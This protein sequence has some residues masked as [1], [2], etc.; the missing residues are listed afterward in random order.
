MNKK[1][2]G[3]VFWGVV[4]FLVV[5]I[6]G[7]IF[8]VKR[9]VSSDFSDQLI[10]KHNFFDGKHELLSLNSSISM[11]EKSNLTSDG[12]FIAIIGGFKKTSET[13]KMEERIVRF[14]WK[15]NINQFVFSEFSINNVRVIIK[16]NVIPYC[17]FQYDENFEFE[18][19][20]WH[21]SVKWVVLVLN[22]NNIMD[23]SINIDLGK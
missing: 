20:Q 17:T 7:L 21:K 16:E 6:G 14:I 22:N 5:L 15:N 9:E 13:V 19:K 23:K 11:V 8:K 4:L 1:R 10:L 12:Y 2:V 18:E 3:R